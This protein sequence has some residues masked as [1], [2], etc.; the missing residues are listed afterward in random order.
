[1]QTNFGTFSVSANKEGSKY[2]ARVTVAVE[3][4][5]VRVLLNADQYAMY[6]KSIT[7]IISFAEESND[8]GSFGYRFI[9]ADN[10]RK[11]AIELAKITSS[12]RVRSLSVEESIEAAGQ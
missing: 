5:I 6:P 3:G 1:M 7:G 12:G 4:K 2:P 9:S 11:H 8:Q 10:E